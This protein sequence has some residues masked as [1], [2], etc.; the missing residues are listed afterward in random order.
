MTLDPGRRST[1][2]FPWI[3]DMECCSG[4]FTLS[5]FLVAGKISM[6]PVGVELSVKWGVHNAIQSMVHSSDARERCYHGCCS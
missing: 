6:L 4:Q 5:G 1:G 3:V 2:G